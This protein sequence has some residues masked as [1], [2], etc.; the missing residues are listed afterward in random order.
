M[1]HPLYPTPAQKGVLKKQCWLAERVRNDKQLQKY[2]FKLLFCCEPYVNALV[3][4]SIPV[5]HSRSQSL[6]LLKEL[7]SYVLA[8]LS[9]H[10]EWEGA[11]R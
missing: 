7:D 6:P 1:L 9:F 8:Q 4:A 11:D 2:I 5:T 10:G 3:L